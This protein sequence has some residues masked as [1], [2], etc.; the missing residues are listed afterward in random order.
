[1]ASP[2]FFSIIALFI[3][4]SKDSRAAKSLTARAEGRLLQKY[5]LFLDSM[6]LDNSLLMTKTHVT[7]DL[8]VRQENQ[9]DS[10]NVCSDVHRPGDQLEGDCIFYAFYQSP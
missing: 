5:N 4:N 9:K 6:S 8:R 10:R 3:A 2:G 1:V 7:M